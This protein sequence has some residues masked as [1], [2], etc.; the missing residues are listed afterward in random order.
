MDSIA[1]SYLKKI[2]KEIINLSHSDDTFFSGKTG[3][4]LYE[5]YLWQATHQ[6]KHYAKANQL[7]NE[8]FENLNNDNPKFSG[9][10]YAN[11]AAG[12]CYVVTMLNKYRFLEISLDEDLVSLDEF[13]FDSALQ[14]IEEQNLDFWHGAFGIVFYF[15]ERLDNI[16]IKQ[17]TEFLIEKIIKNAITSD[18]G[19]YFPNVIDAEDRDLINLSLSHGQTAFLIILIQAYEKGLCRDIIPEIVRQGSDFVISQFK[20]SDFGREKYSFFPIKINAQTNEKTFKNRLGLCYGD[21]NIALLLYRASDF[22]GDS[23][24]HKTA[25]LVG[26]STLLRKDTKMTLIKDAH[27][28]HGAS[29]VAQFYRTLYKITE[30]EAYQKGYEYWIDHTL[31]FLDQHL[32]DNALGNEKA[33]LLNGLTGIGLVLLSYVSKE[34]LDWEKIFLL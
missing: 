27:L 21:L 30:I 11:G 12:F 1:N 34:K 7:I 10:S 9:A 18:K 32:E 29:G 23:S 6:K 5:F 25:D 2:N 28:C 20:E 4:L 31:T 17:N 24:L 8:I 22:L 26:L 16:S 33:S 13:L 19:L 3:M 15:L 14:F